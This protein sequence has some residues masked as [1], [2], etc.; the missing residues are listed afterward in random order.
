[1]GTTCKRALITG[2]AGF[3]GS[4]LVERLLKSGRS[5][6]CLD[7]LRTG[8]RTNFSSSETHHQLNL[9]VQDVCEPI[10]LEVDE[11]WNL[12]CAASPIHYQSDPIHSTR[13]SV[14][15][16]LNVLDLVDGMVEG[17]MR[18]IESDPKLV[19]PANL[20]NPF[21]L[22]V[23]DLANLVSRLTSS[24]SQIVYRPLPSDDPAR[25]RPDISLARSLLGWEPRVAVEESVSKTIAHF[26]AVLTLA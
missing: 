3:I 24:G 9:F 2:G 13:T 6:Y 1:M 12:A 15:G 20:G 23:R 5:V 10:D 18:L 26:R 14:L 21:E 4:H 17:L 11:I 22:T 19:S 25:R 8:S 7:N 16:A